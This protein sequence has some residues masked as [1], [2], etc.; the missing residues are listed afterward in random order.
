M[1]QIDGLVAPHEGSVG[2]L[3]QRSFVVS[4]A[5]PFET[6]CVE[7]LV[8]RI[9][10]PLARMRAFPHLDET[11]VVHSPALRARPMPCSPCGRFIEEE[12]LR[13]P[14]GLHQRVTT[15]VFELE[16][17]RDPPFPV[18]PAADATGAVVKRSAVPVDEP[19]RRRHDDLAERRHAVLQGHRPPP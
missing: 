3:A 8:D 16:P 12:Q 19:A 6:L 2:L 15:T 4:L 7:R 13:E 9:G 10:S 5:R 1:N 11:H 18:E 14:A 17:A